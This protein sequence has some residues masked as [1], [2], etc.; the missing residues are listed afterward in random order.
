MTVENTLDQRKKTYGSFKEHALISQN[1]KYTL[2]ISKNYWRLA[3]DQKEAIEMILHKI[4]RI[5]NGNPDYTDSW[6]DIQG[7]AKLVEDRLVKESASTTK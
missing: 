7:Y 2:D 1:L 3:P 6:H 4:A 5:V